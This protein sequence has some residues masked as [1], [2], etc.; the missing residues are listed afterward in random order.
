MTRNSGE[1]NESVQNT[2]A[3]HGSISLIN[4]Y[5]LRYPTDILNMLQGVYFFWAFVCTRRILVIVLG[6][7]R[8]S[9]IDSARTRV[10]RYET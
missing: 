2:A 1:N 4:L 6:N 9:R 7:E 5:T 10:Y 3:A 8:V